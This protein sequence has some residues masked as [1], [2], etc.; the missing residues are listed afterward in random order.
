[1]ATPN[2]LN[3]SFDKV[4]VTGTATIT[5]GAGTNDS[6]IKALVGTLPPAS[7]YLATDGKVWVM[8]TTTWTQLTI[9]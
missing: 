7:I 1:M 4:S 5:G 6:T 3:P 2:G 9:A 8:Q